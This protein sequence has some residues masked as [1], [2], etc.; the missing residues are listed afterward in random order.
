VLEVEVTYDFTP[1]N[2]SEASN[3]DKD[4]PL[5][6]IHWLF[7]VTAPKIAKKTKIKGKI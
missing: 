3:T 5:N 4:K 6:L 2:Q 1:I 7:G